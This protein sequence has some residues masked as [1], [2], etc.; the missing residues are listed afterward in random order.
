MR[1]QKV[2]LDLLWL[3]LTNNGEISAFYALEIAKKSFVDKLV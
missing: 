1:S 2:T 3:L